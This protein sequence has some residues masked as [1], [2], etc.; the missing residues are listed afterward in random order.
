MQVLANKACKGKSCEKITRE[1][2][3]NSIKKPAEISYITERKQFWL[4]LQQSIKSDRFKLLHIKN[5]YKHTKRSISCFLDYHHSQ[6]DN[7]DNYLN[8]KTP[9]TA[10]KKKK[11]QELIE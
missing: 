7:V 6:P 4:N 3:I 9:V 11:M 1:N 2:F 8:K 5:K 10:L